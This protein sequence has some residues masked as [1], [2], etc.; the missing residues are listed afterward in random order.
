MFT[1]RT[2]ALHSPCPLA[3]LV[4]FFAIFATAILSYLIFQ[5]IESF[6]SFSL[7]VFQLFQRRRQCVQF[8]LLRNKKKK[9]ISNGQVK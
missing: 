8:A 2:N 5:I 1:H 3:K 6:L 4:S 7:L 9:L